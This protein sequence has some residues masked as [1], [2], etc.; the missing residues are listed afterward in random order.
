MILMGYVGHEEF[1][2]HGL[3]RRIL[4][5]E[6]TRRF[7]VSCDP[8]RP[9]TLPLP[10]FPN[11]QIALWSLY[12]FTGGF[13]HTVIDAIELGIGQDCVV[14]TGGAHTTLQQIFSPKMLSVERSHS[15][16]SP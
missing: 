10:L 15:K 4:F 16:S 6:L 13:M 2:I 1:M 5:V 7:I 14:L 9:A 8:S 3:C 12:V 11:G